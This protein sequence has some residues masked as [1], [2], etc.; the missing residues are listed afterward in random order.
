MITIDGCPGMVMIDSGLTL[1]T[2]EAGTIIGEVHLLGMVI[3][4]GT[5]TVLGTGTTT[6]TT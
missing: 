2:T 1:L 6:V 5:V 3:S 4:E